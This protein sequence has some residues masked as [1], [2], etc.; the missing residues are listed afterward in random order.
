MSRSPAFVGPRL[1]QALFMGLVAGSLFS[2]IGTGLS[3][4][5]PRLGLVVFSMTF[6]SLINLSEIPLAS[7]FKLVIYKQVDAGFYSTFSYV[8]SVVLCHLPLAFLEILIYATSVYWL[9][10]FHADGHAFMFFIL[11]LFSLNL[12]VS[13]TF[14]SISYALKNA[15]VATNI[16]GPLTT[17]TALFAGFLIT[18]YKIPNWLI[19]VYWLS[20]YSWGLRSAALNEFHS[21]RYP[22]PT[23]PQDK[24]G[25]G[26][27]YLETM[28]LSKDDAFHGGGIAYLLGVFAVFIFINGYLLASRRSW[29]TTGTRRVKEITHDEEESPAGVPEIKV[30]IGEKVSGDG[31]HM[32]VGAPHLAGARAIRASLQ[33]A[34]QHDSEVGIAFEPMD[35]TFSDLRYVVTVTEMDSTGAK[36][37]YDRALLTGVNGFARAGELTALM[38]SSGAG[39]V[40]MQTAHAAAQLGTWL[41]F[42]SRADF[43]CAFFFSPCVLFCFVLFPDDSD[44]CDRRSQDDGNDHWQHQSERAPSDVPCFLATHWLCGAAGYSRRSQHCAR[45]D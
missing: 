13:V 12:Y 15:D 34:G 38:G 6:I 14:R 19:W 26:N 22:H 30:R 21:G 1:F 23:D 41:A 40:R 20:P 8:F 43:S 2:S 11:M 4:F 44:G 42:V 24:N 32:R 25:M 28:Q 37:T 7:Q 33:S 9:A 45:G 17:L 31:H 39:K 35:L 36:R 27:V 29:L 3:D 16:A 10:D 5:S 18:Q